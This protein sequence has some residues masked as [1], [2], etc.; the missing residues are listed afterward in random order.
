MGRTVRD[1]VE[2]A[3]VGED[4]EDGRGIPYDPL[5]R[6]GRGCSPWQSVRRRRWGWGEVV[7]SQ[8][9]V[10]IVL[11]VFNPPSP[12]M[13]MNQRESAKGQQSPR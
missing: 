6:S 2:R 3:Q 8:G 9:T 7:S 4:S 13:L 10:S 5:R 1:L 12:A 11:S